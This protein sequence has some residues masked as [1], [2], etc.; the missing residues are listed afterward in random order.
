MVKFGE[1]AEC[2]EGADGGVRAGGAGDGC[3]VAGAEVAGGGAVVVACESCSASRCAGFTR[4]ML[5]SCLLPV[6]SSVM[7]LVVLPKIL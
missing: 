4:S 7:V 3:S 5:T 6:T 1:G 2:A